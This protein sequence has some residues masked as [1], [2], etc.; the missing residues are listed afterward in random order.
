VFQKATN[1]PILR[2]NYASPKALSTILLSP[3]H[4]NSNYSA[5]HAAFTDS[6][7]TSCI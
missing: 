4:C 6:R 3:C 2:I 1:E 7:Q 5:V